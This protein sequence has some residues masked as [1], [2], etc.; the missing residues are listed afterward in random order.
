[1]L[2]ILNCPAIGPDIAEA[3]RRTV[4]RYYLHLGE[5]AQSMGKRAETG[6]CLVN[7]LRYGGAHL[8]GVG[9]LCEASHGIG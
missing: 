2:G 8:D 5:I 1:M 4:A 7:C 9:R 3:V 6:M